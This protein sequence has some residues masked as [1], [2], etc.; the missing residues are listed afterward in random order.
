MR[1]IE[2]PLTLGFLF[3]RTDAWSNFSCEE[4][5]QSPN[6]NI[7]VDAASGQ[8]RDCCQSSPEGPNLAA[9]TGFLPTAPIV[10]AQIP[11][12]SGRARSDKTGVNIR[13]RSQSANAGPK[14]YCCGPKKQ[15][16]R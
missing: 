10:G 5:I 8:R 12:S 15:F 1:S 7:E 4:P 16:C 6:R 9:F 13:A 11:Q 2:L 14:G 3:P